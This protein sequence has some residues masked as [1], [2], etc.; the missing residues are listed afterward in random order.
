MFSM[1]LW[2]QRT[3]D[4]LNRRKRYG[5][6]C[7][8]NCNSREK[9]RWSGHT[10]GRPAANSDGSRPNGGRPRPIVARFLRFKDKVAVLE[11]AKKLKGTNI[12]INEDFTEAVRQKRRDLL[13]ALRAA[14]EKGKIAYLRYGKLITRPATQRARRGEEF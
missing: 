7:L 11:R 3:R 12:F 10:T 2:S 4:G 9:S 13:P 6:C 14:R 8:T 1:E 5:R